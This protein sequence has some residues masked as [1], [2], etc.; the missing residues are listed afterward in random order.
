MRVCPVPELSNANWQMVVAL[1][2][3]SVGGQK[4]PGDVAGVS[5]TDPQMR[6]DPR[7]PLGSKCHWLARLPAHTKGHQ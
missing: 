6:A 4:Q 1:R 3:L 7:G 2:L 5:F